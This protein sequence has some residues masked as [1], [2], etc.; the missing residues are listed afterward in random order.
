MPI[1]IQP[2]VAVVCNAICP[3]QFVRRWCP[4]TKTLVF[5]WLVIIHV[6]TESSASSTWM[7]VPYSCM[8]I[9]IVNGCLVFPPR[10][11]CLGATAQESLLFQYPIDFLT[12]IP[13]AAF[14]RVYVDHKPK[15]LFPIDISQE[16]RGISRLIHHVDHVLGYHSW[17]SARLNTEIFA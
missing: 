6:D 1:A 11:S 14:R 9:Q 16:F 5:D 17:K 13:F 10:L 4:E 2:C 12:L 8:C 3:K 7:L 15:V